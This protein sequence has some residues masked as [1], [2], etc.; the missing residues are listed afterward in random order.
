MNRSSPF[1]NRTMCHVGI[2]KCQYLLEPSGAQKISGGR[3][4][5]A[6]MPE[7]S[8]CIPQSLWAPLKD[9]QKFS[10]STLRATF[11]LRTVFLPWLSHSVPLGD[12]PTVPLP[13]A[14]D[15]CR[16]S[17]PLSNPIAAGTPKFPVDTSSY[18]RSCDGSFLLLSPL[19][20]SAFIMTTPTRWAES[21][22]PQI[23]ISYFLAVVDPVE[24]SLQSPFPRDGPTPSP[25]P[26]ELL[27]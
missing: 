5:A 19:S 7:K 13:A 15:V 22:E 27:C 23:S 11:F 3:L 26:W 24:L 2:T 4:G 17:S 6:L 10:M 9:S 8:P 20:V 18:P 21:K 12:V 1:C 16:P 25:W 14:A